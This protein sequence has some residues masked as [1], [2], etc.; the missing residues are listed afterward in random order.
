MK[1]TLE[2]NL[3]EFSDLQAHLRAVKSTD[4]VIALWDI[5][6]YL[7]KE[8]KYNEKLSEPEHDVLQKTR[9]ELY[10]I[11]SEKGINM[12]ELIS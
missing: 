2:F 10:R 6:Q 11:L 5:D 7:R 3:D 8:L 12:D 4:L 1:A 9:D